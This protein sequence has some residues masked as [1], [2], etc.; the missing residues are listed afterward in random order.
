[1]KLLI[2]SLLVIIAC[3]SLAFAQ[4][5][6]WTEYNTKGKSLAYGL[7]AT[8]K[9]PPD[10]IS[11]SPIEGV[12]MEYTRPYAGS[13]VEKSGT[14][15]TLAFIPD[16]SI[17]VYYQT[18]HGVWDEE[19]V[20]TGLEALVSRFTGLQDY[21]ITMDTDFP[22]VDMQLKHIPEGR[23]KRYRDIDARLILTDNMIVKL[24]CGDFSEV[25]EEVNHADQLET[26]CIPFFSSFIIK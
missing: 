13:D 17:P 9:I 14:Y 12:L 11:S 2:F 22:F 8:V 19:L 21:I 18:E 10:F 4:T 16:N 26:V 25:Q 5:D 23:N 15:L 6:N 3:S 7:D 1:M 24:E 20:N